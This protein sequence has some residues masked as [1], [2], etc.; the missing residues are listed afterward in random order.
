MQPIRDEQPSV[1]PADRIAAAFLER[2]A[3]ALGV[4]GFEPR[5][6]APRRTR[7]GTW[8]PFALLR[9]GLPVLGAAVN[10]HVAD[11]GRVD[12]VAG[13][14][15]S[16]RRRGEFWLDA[17]AALL[18]AAQR[19]PR[20]GLID[21]SVE[22]DPGTVG[23]ALLDD[24]QALRPVFLVYPR[25]WHPLER[26]EIIVDAETG[27]VRASRNRVVFASD[28]ACANVFTPS[29]GANLHDSEPQQ[30]ILPF[31]FANDSDHLQ[32][33]YFETFNCCRNVACDPDGAES[34][35]QG[36]VSNPIGI[37]ADPL[38]FDTVTCDEHPKARAADGRFL[39][40]PIDP[41]P[42][43]A[44]YDQALEDDFAEPMLYWSV[45]NLFSYMRRVGD[46]DFLLRS[47]GGTPDQ[48]DQPFHV[49]ANMI[50]PDFNEAITQ[51][52][53]FPLGQG[54]GAQNNPVVINNYLRID[55]AAYIPASTPDT[56]PIP[57][58]LLYRDFDSIVMFQGERRDFA[59]DGEIV[60]HEM[61]HA[62]MGS[63]ND[64]AAYTVDEQGSCSAP[65]ALG[66]GYADYFAATLSNDSLTGEY[67]GSGTPGMETGIRD[68]H[69]DRVCPDDFTGEVHDD[70]WP[71]SGALWDLRDIF[72][73]DGCDRDRFDAAV[74]DAMAGLPPT[75]SFDLAAELTVLALEQM[76]GRTSGAAQIATCV[77]KRR[78]MQ[79]CER[80]VR[81]LG[82]D[83]SATTS[84][85]LAEM[86]V[87]G[88][89]DVGVPTV[90][91]T[92]QVRVDV[93]KGATCTTLH[94][95]EGGG[96]DMMSMLA[97]SPT[98]NLLIK[99]GEPIRF[100]LVSGT[101]THDAAAELPVT[102]VSSGMGQPA[103]PQPVA[104]PISEPCGASYFY[105]FWNSGSSASVTD[106]RASVDVDTAL[107]DTCDG[108]LDLA[109]EPSRPEPAEC[110]A[111]P[112]TIGDSEQCQLDPPHVPV[113]CP[114]SDAGVVS[115]PPIE[116]DACN[117]AGTPAPALLPL[118]LVPLLSRR[119]RQRRQ[120]VQR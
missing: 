74:Y 93:P 51:M 43:A 104:Y 6:L 14:R 26:Y 32:G 24:G 90:P 56:V 42:G 72:V 17:R 85:P 4:S 15:A 10:V 58:D 37:G 3:T 61:T 65:G 63:Y 120:I 97:G 41:A 68:A 8:V 86:L 91:A 28:S 55:N 44:V 25:S 100:T 83:G 110:A 96:D 82:T 11:D 27:A 107:A 113:A 46:P 71:W 102:R 112:Q 16:P 115:P 33:T 101:L 70:S 60:Y 34:R 99:R 22:R 88:A 103:V 87:T 119:H 89:S 9:D 81:V 75:P 105:A 13:R 64:Y 80:V 57:I 95:D 116:R 94:W 111:L 12:R 59:Y 49:T 31:A 109:P 50:V 73:G 38:Y 30:T 18:S 53:P 118:V 52:L 117:C 67:A 48:P 84:Q 78:G 1:D 45:Q 36:S 92:L 21:P 5:Q 29:P 62:V 40:E 77:F 66:E 114:A 20:W 7:L 76:Y 106:V 19:G 23:R 98:F 54:R 79:G 108:E 35:Y 47:H 2:Q 69:N 39:F